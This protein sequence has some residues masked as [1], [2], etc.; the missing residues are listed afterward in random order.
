VT[1][2]GA[3]YNHG[4]STLIFDATGRL[5]LMWPIGGDLTDTIVTE[6]TK[7]ARPQAEPGK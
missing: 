1:P 2:A 4:F 3:V 6:L 5:Q 7:A